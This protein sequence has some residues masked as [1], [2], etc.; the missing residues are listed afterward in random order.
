MQPQVVDFLKLQGRQWR[1][2][3]GQAV[4][5]LAP[6]VIAAFFAAEARLSFPIAPILVG[7]EKYVR[8]PCDCVWSEAVLV[9]P[10]GVPG[11]SYMLLS[12]R[13]ARERL[14]FIDSIRAQTP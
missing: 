12:I 3:G 10:Y 14:L 5:T 6:S 1:T 8:V 9:V 4:L 2:S 11:I 13:S 7:H